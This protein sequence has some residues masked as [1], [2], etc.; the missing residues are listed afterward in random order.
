MNGSVSCSASNCVHNISGLC[1]ANKIEVEGKAAHS[2]SGTDCNTFAE[3]GIKNA[4]TNLTNMN[5][6]GEFK[7]LFS[8]DTIEMSPVISCT[9][10]PCKHNASGLCDAESVMIFGAGAVNTEGTQCETFSQ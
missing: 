3:K 9:A 1:S 2:S 7:Q 6:S 4:F 8:K 10:R 5:I